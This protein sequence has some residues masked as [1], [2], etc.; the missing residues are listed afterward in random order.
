[1]AFQTSYFQKL[2]QHSATDSWQRAH[3]TVTSRRQC[4]RGIAD[5]LLGDPT[6]TGEN[7]FFKKQPLKASV[8]CPEDMEEMKHL[9]KNISHISRRTVSTQPDGGGGA[10][11]GEPGLYCP[12]PCSL[13]EQRPPACRERKAKKTEASIPPSTQFTKQGGRSKR[14]GR[15]PH[16]QV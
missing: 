7:Y 14:N 15:Y 13:V 2:S 8:R 10:G 11:G 1:M 4:V 9:F 6:R 16:T 12:H 3:G 5:L